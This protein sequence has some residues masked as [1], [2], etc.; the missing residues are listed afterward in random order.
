MTVSRVIN[1]VPGKK[2][3][4][5][6]A[7]RVAEVIARLGYEPNHVARHLRGSRSGVIG[8]VITQVNDPFCAACA[9]AVEAEARAHGYVTMLMA[10][11]EDPALEEQQIVTLRRR[12]A[13]GLI[14]MPASRKPSHGPIPLPQG[15]PTVAIDRPLAGHATDAVMIHNRASARELTQHLLAHGHRRI[16]FLG[17]GAQIYT[18]RERLRGYQ[19]AMKA[20]G[21]E[22]YVDLAGSDAS[23]AEAQTLKALASR[24]R[25]TALFAT[26]SMVVRGVMQAAAGQGLTIPA[27]LAVAGFDDFPWAGLVQPGLTLVHQPS[28]AIG[29]RAASM[30]FERL[31]GSCD[32]A[33]RRILL[34]AQLVIRRSCGCQA[35]SAS[36]AAVHPPL[37][38]PAHLG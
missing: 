32:A 17:Y 7:A 15:L 28:E 34:D 19:E 31:H 9:L 38:F 6:T 12:Q 30:L 13:E 27:D 23:P 29:R 16:A 21:L 11:E 25:P 36:H 10:S 4:P 24:D 35:Q 18:I 22:S 14:I 2:V 33:P 37:A 5:E 26:N 3:S 1:Q 8:L 20:A